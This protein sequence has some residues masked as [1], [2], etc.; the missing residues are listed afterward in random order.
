MFNRM[1]ELV[2]A[3]VWLYRA[4]NEDVYLDFVDGST[5]PGGPRSIFYW[6]D[7]YVGVQVLIA[8]VISFLIHKLEG[9]L[10]INIK[11]LH[12]FN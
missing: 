11:Y 8:K 9:K 4:T 1:I 3:A 12:T 10:K 2:W 5:G 6:D 7:K